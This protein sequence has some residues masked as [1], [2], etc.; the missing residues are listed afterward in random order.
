VLNGCARVLCIDRSEL[1]KAFAVVR[2][3]QRYDRDTHHIRI[4]LQQVAQAVLQIRAVVDTRHEHNLG[5]EL[6]AAFDQPAHVSQQI[7]WRSVLQQ[8]LPQ[9]R[10]CRVNGDIEW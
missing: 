3:P 1:R 7:V 9:R 6:N 2:E 10:F 8:I 5:M 4:E